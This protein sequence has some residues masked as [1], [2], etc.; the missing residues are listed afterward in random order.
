MNFEYVFKIVDKE[1]WKNAKASGFYSGSEM[2]IKD[3]YI[4]FSEEEQVEETLIKHYKK[5]KFNFIKSKHFKIRSFD[6]GKLFKWRYVP[7]FIFKA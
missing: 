1:E 4:H 6:L 5:K 7:S 3:G 2:D